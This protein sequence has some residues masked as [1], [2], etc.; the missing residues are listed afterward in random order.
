M[1]TFVICSHTFAI[2]ARTLAEET[3]ERNTRDR[4]VLALTRTVS[5]DFASARPERV[6]AEFRPNTHRERLG[7]GGTR[8]C[9]RNDL[10]LGSW[11]EE[12]LKR[13]QSA[14][15]D[16]EGAIL[17]EHDDHGDHSDDYSGDLNK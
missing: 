8:P 2:G 17:T 15:S 11:K 16:G 3:I 12:A 14:F 5:H 9:K 13:L 6:P 1:S 4:L 10:A 7:P